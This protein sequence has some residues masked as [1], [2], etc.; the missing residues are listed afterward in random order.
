MPAANPRELLCGVV[1]LNLN[2]SLPFYLSKA[3]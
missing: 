1:E 2:V 3:A